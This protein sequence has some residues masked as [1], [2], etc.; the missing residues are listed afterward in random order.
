MRL[1]ARAL[2]DAAVAVRERPADAA[3]LHFASLLRL[4]QRRARLEDRLLDELRG[5]PEHLGDLAVAEAAELAQQQRRALALGQRVEVTAQILELLPRGHP[6]LDSCAGGVR[7]I[8]L[9]DGVA[10]TQDRDRLVVRDPE[11]PRPQLEVARL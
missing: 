2:Q 6:L 8:E 11:Q 4:H 5:D 10:P 7:R 1:E 9:L 3:A